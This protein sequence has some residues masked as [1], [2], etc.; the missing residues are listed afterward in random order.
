MQ[1]GWLVA[2]LLAL[3]AEVVPN[4]WIWSGR[5]L[6]LLALPALLSGLTGL[7]ALSVLLEHLAEWCRNESAQRLFTFTA[8]TLP[9]CSAG[10]LM[11]LLATPLLLL[12]C[13]LSLFWIAGLVSFFLGLVS[14]GRSVSWSVTH[15]GEAIDRA[16]ELRAKMKT[17]PIATMPPELQPPL[18]D[19]PFGDVEGVK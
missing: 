16:R 10:L 19:V 11:S 15:A 8:W 5:L 2:A 6:F 13:S 4:S 3:A 1:L 18:G 12:T 17:V 9:L 7:V 14:V